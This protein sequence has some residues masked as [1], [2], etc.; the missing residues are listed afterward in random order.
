[1]KAC[2]RLSVECDSRGDS[3]VRELRSASPLTL[4]PRPAARTGGKHAVVHLVGSMTAPLGGD[5]LD[6]RIRV[7]AGARLL[8]RGIAA[9]LA[10]PGHHPGGSRSSVH[11][12]VDD[13]GTLEYLP[14][15]TVLTRRAEHRAELRV[16]LGAR[17]R[18]RC[19]EILVLGRS[20]E[21][22][23][24]LRTSTHVTR[25]GT[26]LLR[27]TLDP[28]DARRRA[29]AG[30][31]ASARVVANEPM[32]WGSDPPA[33]VSGDWWSLVPLAAGG[34]VASAVAADAVTARRRLAE[35]VRGHPDGTE[36]AKEHW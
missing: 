16:E 3:V 17:A 24:S 10:L 32:M 30:H 2:A 15:H 20:G 23:G 7:G 26:P 5:E 33:P 18:M 25:Q 14:E 36:L 9:T 22:P 35:A 19:R 1:M 8:L 28:G 27:Q 12:E 11:V 13:G 4:M 34:S 21:V 6:L 31:L 29:S